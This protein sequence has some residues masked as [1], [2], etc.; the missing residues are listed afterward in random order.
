M[1]SLFCWVICAPGLWLGCGD[2]SS[3]P[4]VPDAAPDSGL[5]APP[6]LARAC[7]D[8]LADIYIAPPG[9]PAYDASHRGDVVRCNVGPS[10]TG[11]EV[12]TQATGYGYAG[13]A[14]PSGF[15]V[16]RLTFR[17]ERV[18]PAGGGSAPEGLSAAL[19]LVPE[20]PVAGAPLVV[21]AHGSVGLAPGCAPT[22][23]D[24]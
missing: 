5:G 3:N 8:S 17:T 6:S 2:S 9:L 16:F 4:P 18:P 7:S 20:K 21:F 1:G 12:N 11:A 10:L 14:L 15:W 23:L 19:L 13:P 24:L 22:R